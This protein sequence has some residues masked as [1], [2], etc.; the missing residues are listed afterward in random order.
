[1]S[2]DFP[3]PPLPDPMHSTFDTRAREPSGRP[4]PPELLL[5][6]RLLRVAQDVEVDVDVAHAVECGDGLR[7]G[8]LE[9]TLDRAARRSQRH[10]H[11]DDAVCADVDRSHHVEL[12]DRAVQLRIDHDLERLEYLVSA[13]HGPIVANL[14]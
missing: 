11:V 12:D 1:M 6:R 3:T 8:G 14:G 4:G 13:A 9:V 7:D 10:G 2:V 5:Q